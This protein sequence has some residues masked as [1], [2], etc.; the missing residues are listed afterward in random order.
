[1]TV[2][3]ALRNFVNPGHLYKCRIH[4]I[5]H[6]TS[7]DFYVFACAMSSLCCAMNESDAFHHVFRYWVTHEQCVSSSCIEGLQFA[8]FCGRNFTLRGEVD[9]CLTRTYKLL[10]CHF[11][12]Y[13][14][15]LLLKYTWNITRKDVCIVSG[16]I[17]DLL[18]VKRACQVWVFLR[19]C[20]WAWKSF[21]FCFQEHLLI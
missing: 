4:E 20:V 1:M 18:I 15:T 21:I 7:T 5:S 2:S 14:A 19:R 9:R 8:K 3:H 16:L 10:S 12:L 17:P 6:E 13:W 11:S